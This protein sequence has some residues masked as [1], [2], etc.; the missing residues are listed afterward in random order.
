MQRVSGSIPMVLLPGLNGK[1][2]VWAAQVAAFPEARVVS[3]AAPVAGEG[4]SDYARRLAGLIDPGGPCIVA[5][6]SFGG[7]VAQEMCRY[8]DARCCVLVASSRGPQGLPGPVRLARKMGSVM[9]E[10]MVDLG[11]ELGWET[12]GSGLTHVGRKR[13]RLSAELAE[14]QRWAVRELLRWELGGLGECRVFQIH[15]DCD[16]EFPD[17]AREANYVVRGGG[18]V[19]TVTHAQEVNECLAQVVER[20][21]V[22]G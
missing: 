22:T 5:G 9:P 19:I 1:P 14:F 18:H 10:S 8:L 20:C 11:F 13:R 16:R 12:A 17:G 3:W 15:G 2:E 7:I 6:V 4:L 21:G